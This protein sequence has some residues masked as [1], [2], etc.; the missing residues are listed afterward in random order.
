MRHAASNIFLFLFFSH[1]ETRGDVSTLREFSKPPRENQRPDLIA[2]RLVTREICMFFDEK[3]ENKKREGFIDKREKKG[4]GEK[5]AVG[6]GIECNARK[7]RERERET[8]R[9]EERRRNTRERGGYGL[10]K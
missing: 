10:G 4:G 7:E 3:K 1:R 2:F 5:N 6:K 8:N 9:R